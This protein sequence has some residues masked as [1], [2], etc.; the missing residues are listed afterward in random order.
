M[1]AMPVPAASST[2]VLL[3]LKW[4]ASAR[5]KSES[6][7]APRHTCSPTRDTVVDR[8]WPETNVFNEVPL[9]VS[10]KDVRMVMSKG[11]VT[12]VSPVG[13]VAWNTDTISEEVNVISGQ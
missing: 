5:M 4:S 2:T 3:L 1:E 9:K 11:F 10:L 7:R 13:G 12:L 8:R 6:R